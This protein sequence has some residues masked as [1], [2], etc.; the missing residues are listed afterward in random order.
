MD[1]S[2]TVWDVAEFARIRACR[3]S[4]SGEFGYIPHSR[5]RCLTNRN[6]A[7]VGRLC[8]WRFGCWRVQEK[9]EAKTVTAA[10]LD[11]RPPRSPDD[12]TMA[13][14]TLRVGLI[15]AGGNM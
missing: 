8:G 5:F 2:S 13:T 10:A 3:L 11:R 6:Q 15:G 9:E 12:N 1:S 7:A 14:N 4:N